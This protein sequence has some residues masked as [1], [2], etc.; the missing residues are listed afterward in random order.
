MAYEL[1]YTS[2]PKGLMPGRT[3]FC[4]VAMTKGMPPLLVKIL[5]NLVVY[6][7]VFAHY[8]ANSAA[9]PPSIFHY[10]I[11]DGKRQYELLARV[12]AC[13]LDYTKRSNKIGSFLL[14]SDA[15]RSALG[16]GPSGLLG[17]QELFFTE[18]KGEPQFFPSERTLPSYSL[19]SAKANA[20]AQ[21]TGDAGWASWLAEQYLQNPGKPCF[22]LYDPIRHRNLEQLVRESLMLLPVEKRWKV[23]WNTY[24]TALPPGITCNWRFCV[25]DPES[26]RSIGCVAGANVLDLRR[27]LGGAGDGH[28]AQCARTGQE[29]YPSIQV[30]PARVQA[31]GQGDNDFSLRLSAQKGAQ[32]VESL[33]SR[34][35]KNYHLKGQLKNGLPNGIPAGTG[36]PIPIPSPFPAAQNDS[37]KLK[38][39]VMGGV[40]G[41]L[42]LAILG[43]LIMLMVGRS[44]PKK[45]TGSVQLEERSV[46]GSVTYSREDDI[47]KNSSE[48]SWGEA[49]DK[50]TKKASEKRI[51]IST[52]PSNNTPVP[53]ETEGPIEA[54]LEEESAESEQIRQERNTIQQS[55]R[56]N[57]EQINEIKS[58]IEEN[59]SE[60]Q[61]KNENKKTF[62]GVLESIKQK[63]NNS[64]TIDASRKEINDL[65]SKYNKLNQLPMKTD[66]NKRKMNEINQ[67]IQHERA[68]IAGEIEGIYKHFKYQFID[69]RGNVVER[70]FTKEY[71]ERQ[72]KIVK[73]LARE[74]QV[75]EKENNT[76]TQKKMQYEQEQK[77]LK[78]KLIELDRKSKL[79]AP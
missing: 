47:G 12:S 24:L 29:P 36:T 34:E 32:P 53:A 62:S 33:E 48:A 55:I 23:S 61:K 7:P 19:E 56:E 46:P 52:N 77:E 60:I 22:V 21:M 16:S 76:L 65:T 44:T 17:D 40:I 69:N 57:Q 18:W 67:Q 59:N 4:T 42:V 38:L 43:L 11:S 35:R 13:G 39:A 3:G 14:L 6:K 74:V 66:A 68:M 54:S 31:V 37:T 45:I 30:N 10:S 1:V 58:K 28:L 50:A 70:P 73:E 71:V 9:N 27:N 78:E 49:I 72:T 20:W 8:D 64:P 63:I 2:V 25:N 75:L 26:L 51:E 79:S 15:E 41:F 5:E